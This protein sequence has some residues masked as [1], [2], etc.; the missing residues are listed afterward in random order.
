MAEH[1]TETKVEAKVGPYDEGGTFLGQLVRFTGEEV[2]SYTDYR[3]ARSS[4]DRGTTYTLYRCPG[5]DSPG[6]RVHVERWTRWQGE[7]SEAH[8]WPQDEDGSFY[9]A[10]EAEAREY[11]PQ[12][13]AAIGTKNVVELD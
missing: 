6:Y 3:E 12:L 11:H 5:A 1:E 9:A 13:F 2:G 4:D 7:S 10:T 8:L